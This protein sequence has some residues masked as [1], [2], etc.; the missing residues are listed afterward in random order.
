MS[1]QLVISSVI[2]GQSQP[3][4]GENHFTKSVDRTLEF[5][6]TEAN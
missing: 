4:F 3:V 2:L 1:L 5:R 6:T